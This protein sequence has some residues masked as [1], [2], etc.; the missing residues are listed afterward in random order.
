MPMQEESL[1]K[2]LWAFILAAYS[3]ITGHQYFRIGK[4]EDKIDVHREK[5]EDTHVTKETFIAHMEM[6]QV[7]LTANT[8]LSDANTRAI[9]KLF[10]NKQDKAK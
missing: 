3:G 9:E 4:L 6:I 5:I 7:S 2:V 8:K 10:D 1:W